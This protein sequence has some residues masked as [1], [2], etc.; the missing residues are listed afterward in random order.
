MATPYLLPLDT[1][2][3]S[4]ELAQM[5]LGVMIAVA[6]LI[7][8]IFLVQAVLWFQNR[9]ASEGG[10]ALARLGFRESPK[11]V[12]QPGR[13]EWDGSIGRDHHRQSRQNPAFEG[14]A[15]RP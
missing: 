8:L 15:D 14:T 7:A 6:A 11:L 4:G 9:Q 13:Q 2:P 3:P 12:P 1:L 10:G 5:A